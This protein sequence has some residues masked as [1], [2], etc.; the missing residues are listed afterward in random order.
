VTASTTTLKLTI[1]TA[2][3]AYGLIINNPRWASVLGLVEGTNIP[4]GNILVSANACQLSTP[5]VYVTSRE[6]GCSYYPSAGNNAQ[7]AAAFVLP[8]DQNAGSQ[9][10]WGSN[11]QYGQELVYEDTQ[12]LHQITMQLRDTHGRVLDTNGLHWSV[13]MAYE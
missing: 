6:L 11:A 2:G 12:S 1:A 10:T 4:N 5:C 3:V 8:V 13:T 9:L 7:P